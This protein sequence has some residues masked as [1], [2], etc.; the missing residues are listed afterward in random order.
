MGLRIK[1]TEADEGK[2][3]EIG[4]L[5]RRGGIIVFPTDTVYGI[6]GDPLSGAVVRRVFQIKRR[7][8]KEMPI[9]VSSL[10]KAKELVEFDDRALTLARLFW[11]G[12][13]TLVLKMRVKLPEELTAGK[14]MLGVRVPKHGLTLKII[15]ASGGALIGTSANISGRPPP[16]NAEEIDPEIER[17]ADLIVDGGRTEVGIAST[18]VELVQ[19]VVEPFAGI[20]VIREGAIKADDVIRALRGAAP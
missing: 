15:E 3:M 14:D 6:G 19:N 4:E 11:P 5:V 18:V 7:R 2:I 1:V 10:E 20:K 16:R 17:E 13:L 8:E 9:L 12:P